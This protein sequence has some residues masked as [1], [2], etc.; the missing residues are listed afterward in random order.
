MIHALLYRTGIIA[1]VLVLSSCGAPTNPSKADRSNTDK[2]ATVSPQPAP[3][4][5]P[6]QQ[7]KPTDTNTS[8]SVTAKPISKP[9]VT[10]IYNAL[11]T[12]EQRG[13]S[14]ESLRRNPNALAQCA[15]RMRRLIPEVRELRAR[16]DRLT[17]ADNVRAKTQLGI[18]GANLSNCVTCGGGELDWCNQAKEALHQAEKEIRNLR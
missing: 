6:S 12:L 14:M 7:T 16:I 9:E 15:N 11:K 17:A 8:Q 3:S 1:L 4:Q 18:A 13:R 2:N 5:P 10:N